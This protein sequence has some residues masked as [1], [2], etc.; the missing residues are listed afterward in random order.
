MKG[1][2]VWHGSGNIASDVHFG[3]TGKGDEACNFRLVV[4][5]AH[6]P[7]LY[8]RIN[9]YGGN[10]DVCRMRNLGRGDYVVIDGELMNRKGQDEYLTE[11]RCREIVIASN[12]RRRNDQQDQE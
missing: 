12:N 7:L 5:Q 9:V 1:T 8:I 3:R 6:K 10:V 2:N 11:I 4:E